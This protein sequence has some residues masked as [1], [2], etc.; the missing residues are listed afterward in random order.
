MTD[1]ELYLDCV[2]VKPAAAEDEDIRVL[3][4]WVP[5]FPLTKASLITC[6]RQEVRSYGP[7]AKIAHL[8]F[9]LRG[10][11]DSEGVMGDQNFELDLVAIAEWAKERFGQINFGFLGFPDLDEAAQVKVWP[12]RAGAVM[13][14]YYYPAARKAPE[15]ATIIYL[16]TYGNFTLRDQALCLALANTGYDIY[17]LDPLRYLLHA[18]LEARL[19]PEMLSDDMWELVQMLSASPI[20]IGQPLAAGLAL[21]W[22]IHVKAICGVIAIGRS[23]ASMSPRHIFDNDNPLTYQLARHIPNISPRP[24]ALVT[25]GP[26]KDSSADKELRMLH[27]SSLAPH[28]LDQAEQVSPVFLHGLITWIREN[29]AI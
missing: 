14:S 2:L 23:Q 22:A 9:D 20:L 11:G 16:S 15:P 10:T 17:G 7:G 26:A 28:R 6:A 29:Q 18:S 8:V 21:T 4:V 27:Q 13:E 24:T 25:P 3:R 5:K 12:L 19:T 1:D